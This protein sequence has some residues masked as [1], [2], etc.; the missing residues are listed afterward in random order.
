MRH[1]LRAAL[2]ITVA[3]SLL[4]AGCSDG[5]SSST[6]GPSETTTVKPMDDYR[7]EAEKEIN[8]DNAENALKEI[9]KEIEADSN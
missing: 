3:V 4:L 2:L 8:A 1:T 7:A 9:Q 6:S 5:S